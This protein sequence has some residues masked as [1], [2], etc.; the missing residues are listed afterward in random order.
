MLLQGRQP[1]RGQA[2][3]SCDEF[4][5]RFPPAIDKRRMKAWY[6]NVGGFFLHLSDFAELQR[7]GGG[8]GGCYG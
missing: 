8:G 3:K 5:L 6:I 1:A 4:T 2:C 7:D